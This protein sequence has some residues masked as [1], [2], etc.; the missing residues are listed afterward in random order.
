MKG[1]LC[2]FLCV[3]DVSH[4]LCNWLN[5]QQPAKLPLPVRSLF[6]SVPV[7]P[8]QPQ[9]PGMWS[10]GL[11]VSVMRRKKATAGRSLE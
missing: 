5:M 4:S 1:F 3:F 2:G 7:T 10:G 8:R 9:G 6:S 11:R